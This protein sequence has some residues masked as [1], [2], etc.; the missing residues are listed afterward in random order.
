[1]RIG[2]REWLGIALR[3]QLRLL[4]TQLQLDVRQLTALG[5]SAVRFAKDIQSS[6]RVKF[7]R[8]GWLGFSCKDLCS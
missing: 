3:F 5:E 4:S 8:L 7:K 2:L 1:M 6:V